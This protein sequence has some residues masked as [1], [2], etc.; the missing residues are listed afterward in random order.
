MTQVTNDA[1]RLGD[2]MTGMAHFTRCK[3]TNQVCQ[4]VR[5]V[6]A[7]ICGLVENAAQCAYLVGVGD[8]Q[9]VPGKPA[10]VDFTKYEISLQIIKQLT[11]NIERSDCNKL[12]II[13][14]I[15]IIFIL[16]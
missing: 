8:E 3:D 7:A 14:V 5:T 9:S 16:N 4:A 12:Q 15:F 13:E 1:R 2:G 6:A 11:E 10:I